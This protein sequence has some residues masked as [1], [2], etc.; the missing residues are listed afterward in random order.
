PYD[1]F[2]TAQLLCDID[3]FFKNF[4]SIREES[5]R[6]FGSNFLQQAMWVNHKC[7]YFDGNDSRSF[8]YVLNALQLNDWPYEH[9]PGDA[10]ALIATADRHLMLHSLF[11][12]VVLKSNNAEYGFDILLRAPETLFRRFMT[13]NALHPETAYVSLV[14]RALSLWSSEGLAA[15]I[16]EDI[17][18][19]EKMLEGMALLRKDQAS[20]VPDKIVTTVGGLPQLPNWNWMAYLN[21]LGGRNATRKWTRIIVENPVFFTNLWRILNNGL[22]TAIANYVGLRALIL[23]SPVLGKE[24]EF[25]V[26]LNYDNQVPRTNPRHFA[27]SVLLEKIY[28]YGIGISA[29]LTLSKEFATTYRTHFDKQFALLFH[30]AQDVVDNLIF[31]KQSWL[32]GKDIMTALRKIKNMTLVFG[33]QANFLQYERYHRAYPLDLEFKGTLLVK[34]VFILLSHASSIYWTIN[35]SGSPMYD[36]MYAH[37]TFQPGFEYQETNNLLFIPHATVGFLSAVSNKIHLLTYP[38]VLNH[39][40]RGVLQALLRNNLAWDGQKRLWSYATRVAYQNI[41]DCLE[42]LYD[43]QHIS[44][45]EKGRSP[46]KRERDLLDNAVLYPLF[47]LYKEAAK[48]ERMES[49]FLRTPGRFERNIAVDELFFYNYAAAFCE[50]SSIV[51]RLAQED[52]HVTPSKWRV[53]VPLQNFETFARTFQCLPGTRMNPSSRCKVW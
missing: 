36:N 3:A 2:S 48:R 21:K 31:T 18:K 50:E 43:N 46:D 39:V 32:S 4:L 37:S 5:R 44:S 28:K 11:Q 34:T 23:F 7:R 40:V 22:D 25:L 24:Y 53:N 49:M 35:D 20:F 52:L 41:S 27:C 38:A 10:L 13:K 1:Q 17:C 8:K 26:P 12:V 45:H 15:R 16:S 33:T 51:R 9:F 6:T 42:R 14:H 29:K 30:E 47:E 19:L